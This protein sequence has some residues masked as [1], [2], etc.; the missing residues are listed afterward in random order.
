MNIVREHINFERGLD[1]KKAMNVGVHAMRKKI[2]QWMES[3]G[4]VGLSD[5]HA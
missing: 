5:D 1:P 2:D 3:I 4:K